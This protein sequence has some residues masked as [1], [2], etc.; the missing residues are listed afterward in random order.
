[1]T[2]EF[3]L[4]QLLRDRAAASPDAPALVC[5][6]RTETYAELDVRSSRLAQCL[7]AAGV[8]PGDR[9]AHLDRNSPDAAE[10]LFAA[11]KV[12][13]A[14]VPLNSGLAAPEL[15]AL[16]NDARA[17]ALF[18]GPAPGRRL[19]GG[20]APAVHVRDHGPAE[21]RTAD[22]PQLRQSH[23]RAGRDVVGRRLVDQP[24]YGMTETTGAIVQLAAE[25][26]DPGGPREHLLRSAGK[27]YPWMELE[28]VDPATGEPL[29]P[30]NVGEIR[31]RGASV[32]P[33][34]FDIDDERWGETVN[35]A[36]VARSEEVSGEQ[37]VAFA[38]ERLAGYKLPRR[39][40]FVDELPKTATGKIS[41]QDLRASYS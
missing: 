3:R 36:V 23:L 18:C 8:G 35:A 1:V 32:T 25:D 29:P 11:A 30:G 9:V 27:P 33:G 40:H 5:A 38:R 41:K 7:L 34:Y 37:L 13:A 19:R 26:H 28:V 16:L 21:G 17:K 31:V 4:A 12:G 24:V 15:V 10:L 20:R 2:D 22:Q 39:V 6:G 14:I